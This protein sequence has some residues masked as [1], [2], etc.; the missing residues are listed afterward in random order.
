MVNH[1]CSKTGQ[2]LA[3]STLLLNF[4]FQSTSNCVKLLD[5]STRITS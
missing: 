5:F 1:T 3:V 4:M 2:V